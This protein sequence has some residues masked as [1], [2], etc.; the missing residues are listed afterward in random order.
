[1]SVELATLPVLPDIIAIVETWFND[2]VLLSQPVYNNYVII[3]KDR[4]RNGGGVVLLVKKMLKVFEYNCDVYNT[5]CVLCKL[6]LGVDD[7]LVGCMYKPPNCDDMYVNNLIN[8]I[9]NVCNSSLSSKILIFGDFNFPNI[10]WQQDLTTST[11]HKD[12]PFL[13]CI[14]EN[15]LTQL[16]SF[17]TRKNN[18]LDLVLCRDLDDRTDVAICAPL[19]SSDHEHISTTILF[20][21]SPSFDQSSS[22][23]GYSLLT[24]VKQTSP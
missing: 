15:N 9:N 3:R 24:L 22:S 8:C 5:E 11:Y 19:I 16:V 14:M 7:V 2:S 10:D 20:S 13:E 12:I 4:N 17:P 23:S 18:L 6:K 1:M 21:T